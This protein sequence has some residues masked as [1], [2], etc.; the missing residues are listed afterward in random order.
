MLWRKF[1]LEWSY[2][3]G[4][5]IIVVAGVLIALAIDQWNDRRL[6][7]QDADEILQHLL[8]DLQA[9]LSGIEDMVRH[10]RDKEQSLLRLKFVFDSGERPPDGAQFLQD[11]IVGADYGWNQNR[12]ITATYEEALSSGKFRLIRDADLRSEISRYYF[13]FTD[14]FNRADARETEFP[15]L[16]YQLVPRNRTSNVRQVLLDIDTGLS[17]TEMAGLI[18]RALAS[19]IREYVTAEVN[20]AIFIL[21]LSADISQQGESLI[22]R[23][24]AY[25]ATL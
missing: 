13:E 19:P 12:P 24:E 23:I 22:S 1:K 10:V 21:Y 5:L 7:R 14:L 6:E 18:D 2:A 8:I 4:E 3:V 17:S 15:H 20:L 25:R 9:D 16:S 11:T